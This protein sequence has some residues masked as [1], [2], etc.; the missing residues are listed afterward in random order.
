MCV[1]AC[2]FV[3]VCVCVC[4]LPRHWQIVA[5]MKAMR[6]KVQLRR[7]DT[8]CL[9]VR[10]INMEQDN[11][12]TGV[13]TRQRL[14]LWGT[15]DQRGRSILLILDTTREGEDT[16]LE[17]TWAICLGLMES[18]LCQMTAINYCL[19]LTLFLSH[20]DTN[21]PSTPL[22]RNPRTRHHTWARTATHTHTKAQLHS[23]SCACEAG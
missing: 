17:N 13:R 6:V 18:L 15:E 2:V 5:R 21:W 22:C 14:S 10:M 7:R 9:D 11:H 4:V 20:F 12:D 19:G 23:A 1:H 16:A 3:C 8:A